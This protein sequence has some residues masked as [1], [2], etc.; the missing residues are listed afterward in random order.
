MAEIIQIYME[1]VAT[2]KNVSG[3]LPALVFQ[4]I[5]TD[6]TSHFSKNG[7]NELGFSDKDGPLTCKPFHPASWMPINKDSIQPCHF[8]VPT[9]RW[10][11]GLCCGTQ[12]FEPIECNC[13]CTKPFSSVHIRKLCSSGTEG[14]SQLRA[15]ELCKIE[16]SEQEIWPEWSISEFAARV[17]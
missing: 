16:G 8:L 9:C 11:R 7:G 13:D 4:P 1:E 5:T 15:R 6:M 10:Y 3:I 14:V 2:I 17:F 12:Y